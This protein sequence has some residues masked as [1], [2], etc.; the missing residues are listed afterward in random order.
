MHSIVL[1][2]V[3]RINMDNVAGWIQTDNIVEREVLYE[4]S[5]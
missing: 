1:K 4:V 2:A 3:A 5:D